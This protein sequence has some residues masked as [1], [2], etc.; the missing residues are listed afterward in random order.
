MLKNHSYW[1]PTAD[2]CRKGDRD[3]Q[4]SCNFL[5]HMEVTRDFFFAYYSKQ[6][7]KTVEFWN[8][9]EQKPKRKKFPS[10]WLV[11]FLSLI[12]RRHKT[13]YRHLLDM[14]IFC[15]LVASIELNLMCHV[16]NKRNKFAIKLKRA[17]NLLTLCCRYTHMNGVYFTLSACAKKNHQIAWTNSIWRFH[18]RFV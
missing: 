2:W 18:H 13:V 12:C 6:N 16:V 17:I 3:R 1:M 14:F 8:W 4:Y 11:F 15:Y 7:R 5:H 10:V 9:T